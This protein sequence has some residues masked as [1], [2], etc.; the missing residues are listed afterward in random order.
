MLTLKTVGVFM[1]LLDHV[2]NATLDW[3]PLHQIDNLRLRL[4]LIFCGGKASEASRKGAKMYPDTRKMSV[5]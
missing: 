2:L 1:E 4:I 5:C 3:L